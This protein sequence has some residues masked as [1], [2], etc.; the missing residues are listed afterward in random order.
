[1]ETGISG[2]RWEP[3]QE[4]GELAGTLETG[5]ANE[6]GTTSG[7]RTISVEG[8]RPQG[9]TDMMETESLKGSS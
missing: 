2:T 5:I 1:M 3:Q 7:Q 4:A 8:G 6:A 9:N